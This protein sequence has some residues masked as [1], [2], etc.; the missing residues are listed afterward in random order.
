MARLVEGPVDALVAFER[1]DVEP[2]R[3]RPEV[4]EVLRPAEQLEELDRV[5][6][7]AGDVPRELLEHRQRPLA[8]AVVDRLGDV[9]PRA[10]LDRRPQVGPDQ[11]REDRC[12]RVLVADAPGVVQEVVRHEIADVRDD[13]AP[14][15]LDEQVVP[16]TC[17]VA[18]DDVDLARHDPEQ[19]AQR[20]TLVGVLLAMDR[21]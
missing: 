17:D 1:A 20:E 14:A 2:R 4:L 5:N 6:G 15:R 13:P 7:P 16:Q 12:R 21:R 8:A 10:D 19:R 9:G 18:L 3:L 11:I